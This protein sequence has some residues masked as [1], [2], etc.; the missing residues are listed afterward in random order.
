MASWT[1]SAPSLLIGA[2]ERGLEGVE[3]GQPDVAAFDDA[4]GEDLI[5]GE[6]A[7]DV[8]ELL[9]GADE[10]DVQAGGA[11]RG[12]ELEVVTEAAEVGGQHELDGKLR[13]SGVGGLIGIDVRGFE[14]GDEVRLIDLNP[15]GAGGVELGE[16]LGVGLE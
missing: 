8:V 12:G 7:D 9:G 2:G 11:E 5:C 15:I 1:R 16:D 10:I 14:I 3:I 4:E 13:E 6:L